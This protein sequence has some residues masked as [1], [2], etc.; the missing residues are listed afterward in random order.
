MFAQSIATALLSS[1]AMHYGSMIAG[2]LVLVCDIWW[3]LLHDSYPSP[4]RND[5]PRRVRRLFTGY[6]GSNDVR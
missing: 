2:A 6:D 4:R 1:E 5:R 3:L